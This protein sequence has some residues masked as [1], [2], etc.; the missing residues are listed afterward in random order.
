MRLALIVPYRDRRDELDVFLPHMVEF[1]SNKQIDYK[2][3]VAEQSDDRPFNYGKLCNA[4]VNEIKDNFD[5]FCFHDVDLLPKNDS[6][7]YYYVDTPTQI[8][9]YREGDGTDLPYEQFFGGV[10]IFPKDVF[11]EINGF[12]NDYWGKG[13]IDLDLLHRCATSKVKMNKKYGYSNNE[14]FK[15]DFKDRKISRYGSLISLQPK[16]IFMTKPSNNLLDD[17]TISFFY[18]EEEI[19]IN[20][21][22]FFRTHNGWDFQVFSNDNQVIVQM[23]NTDMNMFQIEIKDLDLS[24]LNHFVVTHDSENKYVHIYVNSNLSEEITYH[25]ELRVRSATLLIGDVDNHNFINLYDFKLFKR[26][27]N[28]FEISKEYYYG[29]DADWLD[30]RKPCLFKENSVLLDMTA[31]VWQIGGMIDIKT[32]FHFKDP[33]EIYTPNRKEG[34]FDIEG[35]KFEELI[36]TYDPDIIENKLTYMDLLEGKID[37]KKY[38]L[39]SI[40]YKVL[41]KTTYDDNT[42]WYKIVT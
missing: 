40:N 14:I 6:S 30:L 31:S 42:E 28:D 22:T 23:F 38:G 18:R 27:L 8:F 11:D 7:E 24:V 4:V 12:S 19:P 37:S 39:N 5:Y 1:L 35:L 17:F 41:N 15:T 33:T 2:I 13:Y 26:K 3:F 32:K 10:V 36:D 29:I 25:G 34:Q 9:G 20:K 21:N 16:S